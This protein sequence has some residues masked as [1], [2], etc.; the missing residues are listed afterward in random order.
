MLFF[1]LGKIM[2]CL[3]FTNNRDFKLAR[4]LPFLTVSFILIVYGIL[5]E[6]KVIEEKTLKINF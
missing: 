2:Y 5:I 4:L 6:K 3:R 1:V